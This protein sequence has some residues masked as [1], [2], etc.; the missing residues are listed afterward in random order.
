MILRSIVT[1]ILFVLLSLSVK[2]Q[3]LNLNGQDY[4][5]LNRAIWMELFSTEFSSPETLLVPREE[6]KN[7]LLLRPWS[8]SKQVYLSGDVEVE[9]LA[10]FIPQSWGRFLADSAPKLSESALLPELSSVEIVTA[11]IGERIVIADS[12]T[13]ALLNP[14]TLEPWLGGIFAPLQEFSTE[15]DAIAAAEQLAE[16]VTYILTEATCD[17]TSTAANPN[18]KLSYG[19]FGGVDRPQFALNCELYSAIGMG[20]ALSAAWMIR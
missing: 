6:R 15:L 20:S 13:I 14:E 18:G 7:R 16:G 10:R 8:R 1:G 9:V 19:D 12:A 5:R 3:N 11:R 17:E 4:R 2:A